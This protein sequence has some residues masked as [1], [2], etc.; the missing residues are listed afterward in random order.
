MQPLILTGL[1]NLTDYPPALNP[2]SVHYANWA[3]LTLSEGVILLPRLAKADFS[4]LGLTLNLG[5]PTNPHLLH[6]ARIR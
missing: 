3:A 4:L 5:P 6:Q 1:T 2:D